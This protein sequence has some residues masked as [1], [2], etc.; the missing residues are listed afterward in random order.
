MISLIF[1]SAGNKKSQMD[2]VYEQTMS[3]AEV[4]Q[5]PEL[6]ADIQELILEL[7]KI[8]IRTR[9]KTRLWEGVHNELKKKNLHPPMFSYIFNTMLPIPI[10]EGRFHV[11]MAEPLRTAFTEA[12]GGG[13]GTVMSMLKDTQYSSDTEE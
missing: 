5:I 8:D 6:P 13:I 3:V 9:L 11:V 7:A 2:R 10:P 4:T 1:V 12:G